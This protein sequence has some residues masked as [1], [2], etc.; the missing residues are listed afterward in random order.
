ML[1]ELRQFS[2]MNKDRSGID[3]DIMVNALDSAQDKIVDI[4][5]EANPYLFSYYYDLTL[6]GAESYWLPDYIPFDY[7][8]IIMVSEYQNPDEYE[9]VHTIWG[10]RLYYQTENVPTLGIPW[11]I[12]DQ[13]ID[14]PM[15]DTGDVMRIWYTRRPKGFFYT[16][17][18]TTGTTTTAV[19][20]SSVTKGDLIPQDDYYIGMKIVNYS[21]NELS[22]ITD[23]D[24]YTSSTTHTITFSPAWQAATTS[25]SVISLVSPLPDKA[26]QLIID[27]AVRR[28]RVGRDDNDET[29]LRMNLENAGIMQMGTKR[30]T[31]YPEYVRKIP[32]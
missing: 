14:F 25:A 20:T 31:A 8:Q 17:C 1:T 10:D 30:N 16:T 4:M 13:N 21:T 29:Y 24:A 2:K 22:R 12:R 7:C 5:L 6:T 28:I 27:E 11:S 26:A 32:R 15:K 3:D 18:S 23:F 9:T 19:F